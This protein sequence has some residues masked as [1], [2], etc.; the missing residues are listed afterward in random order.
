[1]LRLEDDKSEVLIDLKW[2]INKKGQK[3]A[4][5]LMTKTENSFAFYLSWTSIFHLHFNPLI[6]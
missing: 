6:H 1:M 4:T 3:T 5:R 2:L